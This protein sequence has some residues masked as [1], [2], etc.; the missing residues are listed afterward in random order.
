MK[1][2]TYLLL[3]ALGPLTATRMQAQVSEQD[4]LALVALYNATD[5]PN[6]TNNS[7]WLSGP[8]LTWQGISGTNGRVFSISLSNNRLSGNIPTEIG[9][10]T[11]LISL[12]LTNNQLTGTIPSELWQLPIL[13]GLGLNN[14]QLTG[15]LTAEIGQIANLENIALHNNQLSGD[16]PQEFGLLTKLQTVTLN[17]NQFTGGIPAAIAQWPLLFVLE[18]QDNQFSNLPDLSA[19]PFVGP[20]VQNNRLEFDDVEPNVGLADFTYSPQDSFGVARNA[21]VDLGNTLTLT[22]AVGGS[23]NTYQ[24]FKNDVLL[25]GQNSAT[26]AVTEVTNSDAGIYRAVVNNS[27]ASE[28]TLFGRPTTV[29]VENPVF[30]AD[31]LALVALYNAADGPNWTNNTN[32]LSGPLSTWFGVTVTDERVTKLELLTNQLAGNIP[33]EVGQLTGLTR[34]DLNFNA[35][36]GEVP[37]QIGQLASLTYLDLSG[38]QLTQLP[39]EM[40]Q[41]TSLEFLLLFNNLFTGLPSEMA[42]L[43]S[44]TIL[45]LHKNQLSNLPNLS[46]LPLVGL[47][48]EDNRLDFGDLE[49]NAGITGFTYA[50]Q[51]S[52][53]AAQDMTVSLDTALTLTLTSGGSRNVYKW[54]K[55]DTDLDVFSSSFLTVAE[56]SIFEGGIGLSHRGV[57]RAEVTNPLLPALTLYGRPTKVRVDIPQTGAVT[58]LLA[59]QLI[60]GANGGS[61]WKVN[62]IGLGEINFGKCLR[63]CWHP[64]RPISD[65]GGVTLADGRVT[66]LSLTEEGVSGTLAP[67]ISF[68]TELGSLFLR[69]NR[70]DGIAPEIKELDKLQQLDLGR[71]SFG[72]FP[73]EITQI[74]NLLQ[75]HMQGNQLISH[76]QLN[77]AIPAEIGQMSNLE[78]LD[79]AYNNLTHIPP[80]IGNLTNLQVL[81]LRVNDFL[82]SLPPEIGQLRNLRKLYLFQNRLI[83]QLPPEI[84][85][86]ASLEVLSVVANNLK[87]LPAEIGNL[88]NLRILNVGTNHIPVLPSEIGRLSNLE[89]LEINGNLLSGLQAEIGNL[90]NLKTLD[91]GHNRITSLPPEILQLPNLSQLNLAHNN[92]K[93]LPDLSGL[94]LAQ[95]HVHN[96]RLEFDDLEPLMSTPGLVY[97]PQ[98]DNSVARDTTVWVFQPITISAT[99]GGSQNTYQWFKG[100]SPL[101]NQT[102]ATL[103][104]PAAEL[105]DFGSYFVEVTSPLFPALKIRSGRTTVDV[106]DSI[107]PYQRQAL[108]A[109]YNATGGPNWVANNSWLTYVVSVWFGI[110]LDGW[111][112]GGVRLPNNGLQGTLP[113][114]LGDLLD[115]A[116]LDLSHNQLTGTI[117]AELGKMTSLKIMNLSGNQLGSGGSGGGSGSGSG[118]S[119]LAKFT[120]VEDIPMELGNLDSLKVLDLSNNLI[121]GLLPA[122]LGNLDSLTVLNLGNNQLSGSLPEEIGNLVALDTL[123]LSNNSF[124]GQM[125][126]SMTNLTNLSFFDFSDTDLEVPPDSTFQDW[127]GDIPDVATAVEFD[128]QPGLVPSDFTLEQNYPNP[129]NPTTTISFGLPQAGHAKLSIYNLRGQLVRTLFAGDVQAGNHQFMW[130]GTN[131]F[132]A[133]VASGVYLYTLKF[134]DF[135][136]ARKLVLVK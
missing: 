73:V 52:I 26:L 79:L 124:S 119:T 81:D 75:L 60:S 126:L 130:D 66:G 121:T 108:E 65:W 48:V 135:V 110:T 19:L 13:A 31:S 57:Y 22:A 127:L 90:T 32:W 103:T 10:L 114:E 51:D 16:F 83:E 131:D 9:Q 129:F 74:P 55:D 70:L 84:G 76:Q 37:S 67:D 105:Q 23:Q 29:T 91:T 34:L 14:N 44:L 94:P 107:L 125:P 117:P 118:G 49:P 68:L 43:S 40:G 17:G 8:V 120:A 113:T 87:S 33:P 100:T 18:L 95:L 6:W 109:L 101:A 61:G 93:D 123:V 134:D 99:V 92:F 111:F 136:S 71:N 63:G 7:N 112:V 104:V 25:A 97:A 128:N 80:E 53:G 96:N 12:N 54:Y 88:T 86:A 122:E 98:K 69:S 11:G 45:A 85:Q 50:P 21:S 47:S 115:L 5:G 1:R 132:G 3:I 39:T 72:T 38:N 106:V 4:S 62:E 46:A 20:K 64:D 58:D 56:P 82:S 15:S 59:L 28:L 27:I 41:L 102:S 78:I 42:Q 77:G 2:L 30:R 133:H 89:R 36:I 116:V 35:L 24:W